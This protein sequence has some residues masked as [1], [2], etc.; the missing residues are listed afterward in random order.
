MY[1]TGPGGNI[2]LVEQK[3]ANI[4]KL[5]DPVDC[6]YSPS[7]PGLLLC[8]VLLGKCQRYHPNGSPPPEIPEA[9][10]NISQESYDKAT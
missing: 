3:I 1:G 7:W 6:N 10:V 2:L 4:S 8:K 5:Y 9:V